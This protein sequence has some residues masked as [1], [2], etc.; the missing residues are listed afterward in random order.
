M[1]KIFLTILAAILLIPLSA[2]AETAVGQPAPALVVQQ[3]DGKTFDLAAQRGHVALVHFWATWC[4]PCQEEMPVLDQVYKKYRA[5]G[6]TLI[7]IDAERG[8][9]RDKAIEAMK[10][11]SYP[12]AMLGDAKPN[13]FGQPEGIPITYVIDAS[14]KVRDILTPDQT[15]VTEENMD[16]VLQPLLGK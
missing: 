6:L 12:G 11:F 8:T 16:K 9:H 4:A 15:P 5:R 3:F 13:G 7:T 2:H 14:G 1:H 10:A